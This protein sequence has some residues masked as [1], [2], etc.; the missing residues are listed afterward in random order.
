MIYIE[1][2]ELSHPWERGE[3]HNSCDGCLYKNVIASTSDRKTFGKRF[4]WK[5]ETQNV[6]VRARQ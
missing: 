4:V 3:H 1:S 2:V 5:D 6:E